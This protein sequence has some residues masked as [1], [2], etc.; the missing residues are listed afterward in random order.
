MRQ[1]VTISEEWITLGNFLKWVGAVET[2]GQ[3]KYLLANSDVKVN[4]AVEKRRGRKLRPGDT[5][6]LRGD[7]GYLIV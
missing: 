2:G 3:A 1:E 6:D 7:S 5:I 4:G